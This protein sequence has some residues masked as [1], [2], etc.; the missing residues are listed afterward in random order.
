[1]L[2]LISISSLLTNEKE[3]IILLLANEKR[4][5]NAVNNQ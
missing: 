3:E 5:D 2:F 1:M 4:E